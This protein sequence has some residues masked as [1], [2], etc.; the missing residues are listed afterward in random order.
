MSYLA[1]VRLHFAGRFQA[2][3]STVNND[4]TH[5]DNAKF[6]P[7]F[8]QR[9]TSGHPNGWWNPRGDGAWRLLACPVTSA[10]LA[11]GSPVPS[12]DPVRTALVTDSDRKVTAKLADLDP[13]QQLVS[14]IFGLEIRLANAAGQTLLR[15]RFRPA[16]FTDIWGRLQGDAQSDANAGAMWQS[17]IED[18]EWADASPSPFLD[19]LRAA[20]PDGLLSIKFNV[21]RYSMDW[22]GDEFCRGRIVGTL[23]PASR[24]EP[25]HFVPGRPLMPVIPPTSGFPVPAHGIYQ[26]VAV[27]DAAAGR[28]RLDL[29]NALPSTAAGNTLFD[30]GELS[31]A[32]PIPG[33]DPSPAWHVLDSIPY[34]DANWYETTAGVVDLPAGRRLTAS[35]LQT[36][37]STP[38]SLLLQPAN[39]APLAAVSEPPLGEYVRADAFVARLSPG[40]RHPV[41]LVASRYGHPLPHARIVAYFDATWLQA[42]PGEPD[43]ATPSAALEFPARIETDARGRAFLELRAANPGNPRGYIDGQVFGVRYAL[44]STLPPAVAYPFN[45]AD[46]ISVLVWDDFPPEPQPTWFGGLDAVFRQ[47]A[48]LYPVMD[49]FLD[50]GN[51]R[52]VCRYRP[53]LLLAFG[54]PADDP[55]A[56]PV[57][58][59]LSPA[60]RDAILRW[61]SQLGPDGHPLLG[62]PPAAAS[63]PPAPPIALSEVPHAIH[64]AHA[65]HAGTGGKLAALRRRRGLHPGTHSPPP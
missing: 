47:Y 54:L 20:S 58:R 50:L 5:F 21:D 9:Q 1:A 10:F 31:L 64:T 62:T 24:S 15:G 12:D 38:I 30:L 7:E 35:E 18:L 56:M 19:A 36:L 59:D 23:G 55:N 4:I 39:A 6:L 34:R 25:A 52:Q 2:S 57:T 33:S 29:G 27:V 22:N 43:V 51:Y 48:N 11:D 44:E 37:A 14:M 8:Q 53:H 45:P 63:P 26:A 42:G 60:K 65:T 28:I 16:P 32:W 3:V 13:Q 41:L 17:V 49:R 40:D 61:L 46:F